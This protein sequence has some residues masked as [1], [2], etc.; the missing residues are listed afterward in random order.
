MNRPLVL[1]P[2]IA[3]VCWTG[4]SAS[5]P[6]LE[7]V[8]NRAPLAD[9]SF[10]RLPLT[11]VKPSGW[12]LNQLRIQAAGITGHLD[13]FWPDVGPN[14]AWLGG[15]GE[16]WER[17]PYYLDGL[18]PLAYLLD[19]PRLIAKVKPWVEWTLTHQR[20]DGS[21][22][23]EKNRDWWP[24]M[25]MLKVLTQYQEASGD[26]R[27][28]PL[29]QKYFAYQSASLARSP[30]VSWAI[31]RWQDE[32]ASILWLYN[33]TGDANLLE[34]VRQLKGQGFDWPKFYANF[35]FTG[36]VPRGQAKH[37]SHGVNNGMGLKTA[38]LWH[39]ISK[40]PADRAA[41]QKELETLD[42]FQGLP[43]G[44]FSGDEHFSGRNPSQG[45]ETC[46]VVEAMFSLELDLAV[47][48]D[49]ALGDRLEKIAYNALPGAQTADL[50]G[51]Q[52]DQQPNQV[53]SSLSR[54]QWGTNGPESNLFGLEP[55]FGCCTANLHQGWPKFA[56]S[57]WMGSQDDGLVA[58]AYAPSTVRIK[59]KGTEVS[60][61]EVTEYPFRSRISLTVSPAA[62]LRFPLY[63]RI[64]AW[65]E[66]AAILV[67]GQKVD[68]VKTAAYQRVEREWRKGDRVEITLPMAVQVVPG[69]NGSVSVERGPL[70]FSLRIGESWAKLRQTGPV[71]DWEVYPTSPWN[72]GLRLNG[73]PASSFE[74][75][76]A[77]VLRQPFTNAAPPVVLK[78]K[79]RRLPQWVMV[80]D[81]AAAPPASPA[82]VER[83]DGMVKR[84][85]DETVTL[86]PY[87]AARLRIT[88][89]PVLGEDLPEPKKQ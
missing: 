44:M 2:L 59:V 35:P 68:G 26:P 58:A 69:Y 12:L 41:T 82:R 20:P 56:A 29:M 3:V 66:G 64:P 62:P 45:I 89:F 8:K 23:P 37:D 63:L 84:P 85:V 52:Y 70:V 11:A 87:A 24:N 7:P 54:R 36:A 76:E 21:I 71:T 40:D 72:Y 39:L 80:D 15:A 28:I 67:N 42:K 61:D 55:N 50:W 78:V 79:A 53:L 18:V 5:S 49:A 4:W 47:V 34:L 33:R 46:A 51:H 14:S 38:A 86:I 6:V 9:N 48:G 57:L 81:S 19:D 32:L 27:V 16:G 17:G 75:N 65:A 22:G 31:Y 25:I 88:S 60:V 74:V 83:R 73:N 43:N 1:L 13:E 10:Y 30:L 77:P